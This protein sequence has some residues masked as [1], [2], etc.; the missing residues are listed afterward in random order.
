[1]AGTGQS[2]WNH[3]CNLCTKHTWNEAGHLISVIHSV[4]VDGVSLGHPCCGIQD[5]K[6]AL[7]MSKHRYCPEHA[8]L[9]NKC[10]VNVCTMNATPGF[11]TCENSSHHAIELKLK[12][13]GMSISILQ[14]RL[15]AE[16]PRQLHESPANISDLCKAINWEEKDADVEDEEDVEDV[17]VELEDETISM[18]SP[19]KTCDDKPVEGVRKSFARFGRRC[20]H[21]EQL[22]V[23]S[24]GV[25][26]GRAT[27][28]S[29]EGIYSVF[30]ST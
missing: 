13:K 23:T 8:R 28:Y 6:K 21:N 22:C 14:R 7:A 20:T 2:E 1:M 16:Y 26:L 10:A 18:A 25:I 9:N 27:F 5:C 11:K 19:G 17:E 12:S 4:I 24:C 30:V 3:S 15:E 29:A